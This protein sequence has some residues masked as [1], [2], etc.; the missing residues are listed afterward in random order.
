MVSVFHRPSILPLKYGAFP[1]ERGCDK[2]SCKSFTDFESKLNY[3]YYQKVITK[4]KPP[5]RPGRVRLLL[6]NFLTVPT[7]PD[8]KE[9]G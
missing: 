7:A 4:M 3:L 9:N 5:Y 1:S 8:I 2:N 6:F